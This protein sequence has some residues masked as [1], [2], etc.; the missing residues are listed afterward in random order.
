MTA[1]TCSNIKDG[2]MQGMPWITPAFSVKDTKKAIEFYEKAFGFKLVFK[3]DGPDGMPQHVH[4]QQECSGVVMFGLEGAGG[5]AVR[6][7]A[8][9]KVASPVSLYV[10]CRDV[11]ELYLKAQRAGAQVVKVPED[12][13]W[14]DRMCVLRDPDGYDWCFATN[15]GKC[16]N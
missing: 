4:M 9:S 8:N 3:M 16:M 10:Y 7:P 12:A 5:C 2:R 14:G 11:D 13:F 1:G 15:L 6:T